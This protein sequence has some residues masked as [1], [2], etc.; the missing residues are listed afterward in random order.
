MRARTCPCPVILSHSGIRR[1]EALARRRDRQ[2]CMTHNCR[3]QSA[4][5]TARLHAYPLTTTPALLALVAT[6]RARS[7]PCW[8]VQ[9]MLALLK[10]SVALMKT[11][12]SF[13]PYFR[14]MSRPLVL[15]I[16]TGRRRWV[17]SVRSFWTGVLDSTV[18]QSASWGIA[19]GE[20]TDVSSMIRRPVCSRR[21]ISSS[22]TGVGTLLRMFCRPSRGPTSTIRTDMDV[23]DE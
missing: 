18:W 6:A 16:S 1:R 17:F 3:C 5:E 12:A 8:T 10:P 23:V 21:L 15:G 4:G 13:T 7:I 11:A 14:A 9:L 2:R 22:L 19:F 20:T